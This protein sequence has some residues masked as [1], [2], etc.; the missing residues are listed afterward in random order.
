MGIVG[1]R[2]TGFGALQRFHEAQVSGS[3]EVHVIQEQSESPE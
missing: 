3:I 1:F 2:F